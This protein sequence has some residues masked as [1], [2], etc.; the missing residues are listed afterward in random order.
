MCKNP[1]YTTSESE[2]L[3]LNSKKYA[4]LTYVLNCFCLQ[5][6][7]QE[8]GKFSVE[9]VSLRYTYKNE[10]YFISCLQLQ[11][12]FEISEPCELWKPKGFFFNF[13]KK[14]CEN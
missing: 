14:F 11:K 7:M 10:L 5:M 4:I 9:T 13:R 8:N 2:I 6:S 12:L 3:C 1:W